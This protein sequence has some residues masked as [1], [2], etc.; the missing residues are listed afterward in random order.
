MAFI[1]IDENNSAHSEIIEENNMT[2]SIK[3]H[4]SLEKHC[5]RLGHSVYF[6]YCRA[7]GN[8]IPCSRIFD[9]WWET[10]DVETFMRMRYSQETLVQ[11]Q[12]PPKSK[13]LSLVELI[14]QAQKRNYQSKKE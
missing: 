7:P 8:Q 12:E 13:V 2:A 14:Q 3:D 9:C 10:F 4:D 6:S 11:I 1:S 5:P